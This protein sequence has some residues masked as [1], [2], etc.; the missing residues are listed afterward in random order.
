M[1]HDLLRDETFVRVQFEINSGSYFDV[2][3]GLPC[4]SFS[5]LQNLNRGTRTKMHPEGDGTLDRE[6]IGNQLA[7]RVA[8]LCTAFLKKEGY[9]LTENP[10]S[11][12]V[13]DFGLVLKLSGFAVDVA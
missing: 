11:S 9:F 2:H 10:R 12:R 1:I 8:Q 5:L 6:N 3:F 7:K 13:W 4:S